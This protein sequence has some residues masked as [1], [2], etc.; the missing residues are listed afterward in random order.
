MRNLL[1]LANN[2][3]YNP[4]LHVWKIIEWPKDKKGSPSH[5]RSEILMSTFVATK[6]RTWPQIHKS[7]SSHCSIIYFFFS[8]L[9]TLMRRDDLHNLFF[10]DVTPFFSA[11]AKGMHAASLF[12]EIDR[13]CFARV[14][15]KWHYLVA[16][17]S[18]LHNLYTTR[19]S[20]Q[21]TRTR[22]KNASFFDIGNFSA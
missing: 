19:T 1:P 21:I 17:A 13:A 16:H 10:V 8:V 5:K 3:T 20:T 22:N 15:E 14:S 11:L 6:Q 4:R 2:S 9:R 12:S 7:L 18:I